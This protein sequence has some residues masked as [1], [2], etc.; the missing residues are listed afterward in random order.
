MCDEHKS[1]VKCAS[2][3]DAHQ[4]ESAVDRE[5][6]KQHQAAERPTA[7]DG[8]DGDKV[9]K[10]ALKDESTSQK[11]AES[12]KEVKSGLSAAVR[13]SC[14]AASAGKS[15]LILCALVSIWGLPLKRNPMICRIW[16]WCHY[17]GRLCNQSVFQLFFSQAR[18][19]DQCWITWIDP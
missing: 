15:C 6:E 4:D 9:S 18:P 19:P 10:H 12:Q 2:H 11:E 17:G 13:I 14:Q 1:S 5:G 8:H 7:S 3:Q 16:N